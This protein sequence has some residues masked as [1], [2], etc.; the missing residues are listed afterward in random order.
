MWK[1][2]DMMCADISG[3]PEKY[4][5]KSN[6]YGWRKLQGAQ[7]HCR[8]AIE[9]E[10]RWI[11]L[12]DIPDLLN[13]L[14]ARVTSAARPSTNSREKSF[15]LDEDSWVLG[16][17]STIQK[18]FGQ[19]QYLREVVWSRRRKLSARRCYC[20]CSLGFGSDVINVERVKVGG[21]GSGGIWPTEVS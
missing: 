8:K 13:Q 19:L 10:V 16:F 5:R 11:K 21:G 4:K 2:A 1:A 9:G 3:N 15:I 6:S 20:G 7:V 12:A 17:Y 14:L 18:W